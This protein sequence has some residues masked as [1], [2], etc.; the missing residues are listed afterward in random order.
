MSFQS[1]LFVFVFLPL[2]VTLWWGLNHKGYGRGAQG[3]LLTASLVFYGWT[4]WE[5]LVILVGSILFHYGVGNW[6]C[7]AQR[8]RKAILVLGVV[9]PP[10]LGLL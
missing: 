5:L 7:R 10:S 6:L 4:R 1:Y 9:K 8:R 2:T 3:V